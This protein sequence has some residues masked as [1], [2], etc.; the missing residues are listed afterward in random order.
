MKLTRDSFVLWLPVVGAAITYLLAADPPTTWD[1]HQWLQ[2][3][4]AIVATVS[5]KLMTSPLKHSDDG[6][7]V[8]VTG[9]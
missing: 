1:Y 3:A 2:A 7:S 9:R 8:N 6:P 5:T 4:A